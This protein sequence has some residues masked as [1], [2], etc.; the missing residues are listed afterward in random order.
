MDDDVHALDRAPQALRIRHVA[1]G[2]LL[3]RQRRRFSRLALEHAH[4]VARV[5]EPLDDVRADEAGRAGDEDPHDSKFF[6]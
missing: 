3:A 4:R 5:D 1:L 2:R 6:Q